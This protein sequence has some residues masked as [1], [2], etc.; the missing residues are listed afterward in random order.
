MQVLKRLEHL[1]ATAESAAMPTYEE[2]RGP[3]CERSFASNMKSASNNYSMSNQQPF[4][5]LIKIK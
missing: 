4:R 3:R 5:L 2:K 1:T